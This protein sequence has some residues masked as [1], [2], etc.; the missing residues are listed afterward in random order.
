MQNAMRGGRG[1]AEYGGAPAS[2]GGP[3]Q[4]GAQILSDTMGVDFTAYI[5]RVVS[6]TKRNWIPLLPEEIQPPL[7]KKGITVIRFTIQP[8]GNISAM[9]LEGPSGDRSL[10]LA[11]WNG[12]RSEGQFPPLPK[13]F[14]GPNLEL[15]FA[16]YCN[17]AP[18]Q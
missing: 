12:I 17:E 8:D 4:S 14:H 7:S 5:R 18:P 3:L 2:S 13:A 1:G 15:R 16:F 10:D 6:D 11:A 9:T